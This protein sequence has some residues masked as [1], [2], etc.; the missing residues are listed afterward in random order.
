M[1]G[2][3]R[4][5]SFRSE[6]SKRAFPYVRGRIEGV[7]AAQVHIHTPVGA[8]GLRGSNV[9]GGPIDHGYGVIVHSG[10]VTVTGGGELSR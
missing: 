7:N 2:P 5:V 1:T 8:I 10:E 9:W 6:L 3:A 4:V